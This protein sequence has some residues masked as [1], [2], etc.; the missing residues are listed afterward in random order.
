MIES[1]HSILISSTGHAL[2]TLQQVLDLVTYFN[3]VTFNEVLHKFYV[4]K[5]L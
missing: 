5:R 4:T 3:L 2:A 1:P